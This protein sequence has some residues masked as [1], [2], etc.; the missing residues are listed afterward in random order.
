MERGF[1]LVLEG[2]DGSGKTTI[3]L[4]LKKAYEERGKP[5]LITREPTDYE[6]GQYI[7]KYLNSVSVEERDPVFEALIFAADRALHIRKRIIPHLEKGYLVI[8][9]RYYYSSLA[10]QSINGIDLAWVLE[11]N[12]FMLNPDLA[13]F[14][15]VSPEEAIKRIKHARNVFEKK[16]FLQKVYGTYIEMVDKGMLIKIDGRKRIVDVVNEIIMLIDEKWK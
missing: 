12:K 9:D 7:R 2:I 15:D 5:V 4:K 16:K 3:A 14:L 6:V 1:F 10:Y 13:I 8:S 11:V